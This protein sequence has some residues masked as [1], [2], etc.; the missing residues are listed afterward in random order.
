MLTTL[1]FTRQRT[2]RS[3]WA[4][5]ATSWNSIL[6]VPSIIAGGGRPAR[7]YLHVPLEET[8]RNFTDASSAGSGRSWGGP[9]APRRRGALVARRYGRRTPSSSV[10]SRAARTDV[11][12]R[13]TPRQTPRTPIPRTPGRRDS[14]VAPR[15]SRHHVTANGRSRT[16]PRAYRHSRRARSA[17]DTAD[18]LLPDS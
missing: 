8:F 14:A 7:N 12:S 6:S 10:L 4:R 13:P 11:S 3:F 2:T 15:E 17:R 1:P 16:D 9:R 5:I 18:R